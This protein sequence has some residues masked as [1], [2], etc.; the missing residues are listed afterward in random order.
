[1]LLI[2]SQ[3]ESGIVAIFTV[4]IKARFSILLYLFI[5]ANLIISNISVINDMERLH[6]LTIC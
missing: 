6:I 2:S 1:M 4:S 3:K 5:K